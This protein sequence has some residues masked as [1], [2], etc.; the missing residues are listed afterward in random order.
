MAP[1]PPPPGTGADFIPKYE[2]SRLSQEQIDQ[3]RKLWKSSFG[4]KSSITR[5]INSAE[6]LLNFASGTT[7]SSLRLTELTETNS[8]CKAA[9]QKWQNTIY[10][11]QEIDGQDYKESIDFQYNRVEATKFKIIDFVDRSSVIPAPQIGQLPVTAGGRLKPISDFKPDKLSLDDPPHIMRAWM[12]DFSSYYSASNM[13]F[14]T[15]ANQQTLLK[16]CLDDHLR[17]RVQNEIQSNTEI[18]GDGGCLKIIEQEFLEKYPLFARRLDFFREEQKRGELWTDFVNRL[19]KKGRESDLGELQIKD[20]YVMRYLCGTTDKELEKEFFKL[21]NPTREDLKTAG[22][23]YEVGINSREAKKMS[24]DKVAATF[25]AGQNQKRNQGKRFHGNSNQ[26]K[27]ANVQ[28]HNCGKL[29]HI[30]PDCT[31]SKGPKN[32]QKQRPNQQKSKGNNQPDAKAKASTVRVS[33]VSLGN[34]KPKP[35][36]NPDAVVKASPGNPKP[37][38]KRLRKVIVR[39][40]LKSGNHPTPW[41]SLGYV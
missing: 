30:S 22:K 6:K 21:K 23:Q 7:P 35:K 10:K 33:H 5:H 2:E 19:E 38:R 24:N 34:P 36:L 28:C 31:S 12:E 25:K 16:K 29:G 27:Y 9:F 4:F 37:R 15:L 11:I 1:T 13:Q 20:I 8:G 3:C 17:D 41:I 32:G 18:F 39:S 14:G 26:S 40:T